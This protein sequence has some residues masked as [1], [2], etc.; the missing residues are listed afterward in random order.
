MAR[1]PAAKANGS[2]DTLEDARIME[3]M[4]FKEAECIPS[5][6]V[7]RKAKDLPPPIRDR[8]DRLVVQFPKNAKALT[9]S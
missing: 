9:R 3:K 6:K 8:Q 4:L 2:K 1:R 7:T 5:T